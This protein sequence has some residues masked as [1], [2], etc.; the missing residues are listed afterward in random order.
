MERRNIL[1]IVIIAILIV[2]IGIGFTLY[3]Q[4]LLKQRLA[5]ANDLHTQIMNE[6]NKLA[7]STNNKLIYQQIQNDKITLQK[8][9]KILQTV[10]N[11]IFATQAQKDYINAAI[12]VNT[13][14]TKIKDH[15]QKGMEDVS[16]GQYSNALIEVRTMNTQGDEAQKAANKRDA[17]MAGHPE[18]FGFEVVKL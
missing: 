15:A 7:N 5:E 17:I 1:I 18:E 16:A 11:T 6:D 13:V 10:S 9:L 12:E 2:G 4:S 14:N 8:E 3:E